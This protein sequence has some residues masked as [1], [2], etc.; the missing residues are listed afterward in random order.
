MLKCCDWLCHWENFFWKRVTELWT[1]KKGIPVGLPRKNMLIVMKS[2]TC[3][4]RRERI[5]RWHIRF[6]GRATLSKIITEMG[7]FP[8]LIITVYQEHTKLICDLLDS[9]ADF[10]IKKMRCCE[11]HKTW[12][13][14]LTNVV[15]GSLVNERRWLFV[16]LFNSNAQCVASR[17]QNP[18][19][20]WGC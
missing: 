13:S 9:I 5:S 12:T 18:L 10:L 16:L 6:A 17:G 11:G 7:W 3:L 14:K 4:F 2:L 15:I 1:W 19:R 20:P 8:N